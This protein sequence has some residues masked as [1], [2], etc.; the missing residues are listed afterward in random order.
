MVTI[1]QPAS[2]VRP[3]IPFEIRQIAVLTDFSCNAEAALNY[4]ACLAREYDANLVLSHAYVPPY[5]AY[6]APEAALVYQAFDDLH[7]GLTDRL[8][9]EAN[10]VHLRKCT[11]LLHEGTP[12]E[13]LELLQDVDLIVVGTSGQSGFGKVTLGSTAETIFRSSHIPVLTVGPR[14]RFSE[15][16]EGSLRTIL[17]GTDFSPGADLA[18]PYALSIARDHQSTVILL[19]VSQD[20][21]AEFSFERTI[22]SARPLDQMHQ[23]VADNTMRL[24]SDRMDIKYA[25]GFGA[26]EK[27]ILQEANKLKADLIVIGARGAGALASVVSHFGGGTAYHVAASADCPVLTIRKP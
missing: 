17:Y 4:A 19:H 8:L 2:H 6:A 26:P 1:S 20:R 22:A 15:G 24:I 3:T 10:K 11:I 12:G 21:D 5:S 9:A 18:L 13:L 7:Q 25:V 23:L 16:R 27:V 14:C